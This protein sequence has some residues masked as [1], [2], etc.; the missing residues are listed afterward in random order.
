M[1]LAE[2]REHLQELNVAIVELERGDAD[3]GTLEAIFRGAHSMK[4]MSAAMGF[5]AI[6]A[7]THAIEDALEPLRGGATAERPLVDTLLAALDEIDAAIGRIEDGADEGLDPAPLV[8]RL[9]ASEAGAP[10]PEPTPAVTDAAPGTDATTEAPDAGADASAGDG[11]TAGSDD[12]TPA[13]VAE[14]PAL[15][16]IPAIPAVV[17]ATVDGRPLAYLLARLDD[18]VSMPAV[19]AYMAL[20]ACGGYGEVV[21]STPDAD[22]VDSFGGREIEVWIAGPEAAQLTELE[23]A[24]RRVSDVASASVQTVPDDAPVADADVAPTAAPAATNAAATDTAPAADVAI[25]DGSEPASPSNGNGNGASPA[26]AVRTPPAA[27]ASTPD[28][29]R[30]PRR[31]AGSDHPRRAASVRVDADRLDA[32]MHRMGE[33]VVHRTRIEALAETVDHLELQTALQDMQRSSHALQQMVMQV[34]MVPVEAV[35]VR[36]PRLVRDLAG[37]LGKRVELRLE[38]QETELDRTVVDALGDPLVHLVRNALDHGLEAPADRVAA[39][40]SETGTVTISARQ[41]GGQVVIEVTD[42]GRGINPRA[43]AKRALE[44]GVIDEEQAASLDAAGAVELLFAPG[45]ST[46]I[47]TSDVSGRGVGMD[48]V[49][50]AV[51]ELGGDVGMS[52][53]PGQG[54]TTRLRLPLTLAITSALLVD[55]AGQPFAVPLDRVE[56]IVRLDDDSVRSVAGSAVLLQAESSVPLLDGPETLA[57]AD[58]AETPYALLLRGRDGVIAMS[59]TDLVGQRELVTR[60]MPAS[61]V[62]DTPVAGGAVLANGQIALIVDVDALVPDPVR[63]EPRLAAAPGSNR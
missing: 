54:T 55:V 24:V 58:A 45:F 7:V 51:G 37:Q 5:A 35:L 2:A 17:A 63:A 48:A 26:A 39:G 4:G 40:K 31:A 27:A 61:A 23:A 36:L 44:R 13:P 18:A 14:A 32:L 16:A 19:R 60:P 43:V 49:R 15:P 33:L 28:A 62:R 57:T 46:A 1:F 59:V 30:A 34:R 8:A 56:R 53:V 25:A 42:D 29:A 52:S 47:T 21:G 10:T 6:A 9:R 11:P 12:E 3:A 41:A 20:A 38:G 50:T 22:A